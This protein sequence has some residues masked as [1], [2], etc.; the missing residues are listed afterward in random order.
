M[1]EHDLLVKHR[2]EAYRDA[3]KKVRNDIQLELLGLQD[4]CD[5]CK[6]EQLRNKLQR[7][8]DRISQ[9]LHKED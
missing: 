4:I 3:L 7:R 6:D 9:R 1:N 5:G 8:I 2:T